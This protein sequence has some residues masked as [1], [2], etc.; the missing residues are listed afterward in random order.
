MYVCVCVLIC[1]KKDKY[2]LVD[3]R[4]D[5]ERDAHGKIEKAAIVPYDMCVESL[6]KG[7]KDNLCK[8]LSNVISKTQS[9]GQEIAFFCAYGERAAIAALSLQE[10]GINCKAIIA[11]FD[12]LKQK[13]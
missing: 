5:S 10:M 13:A 6:Q 3:L 4:N 7:N 12:D 2:K 1:K 11:P 9:D 8:N